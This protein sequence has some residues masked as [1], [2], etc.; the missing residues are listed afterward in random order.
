VSTPAG[1]PLGDVVDLTARVTALTGLGQVLTGGLIA[2]IL[3]W[4]FSHWRSRRRAALLEGRGR[5]P[6]GGELES[7][8]L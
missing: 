7:S 2:I 5:H 6:S 3:T 1:D 8:S 4:W